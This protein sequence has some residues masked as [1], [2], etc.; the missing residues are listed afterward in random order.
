[1]SRDERIVDQRDPREMERWERAQMECRRAARANEWKARSS[2]QAEVTPNVRHGSVVSGG[3]ER[4]DTLF[5]YR[6]ALEDREHPVC[7]CGH[8]RHYH[9]A[10]GRWCLWGYGEIE[11]ECSCSTWRRA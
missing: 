1:M 9:G 3:E 4:T 8:A 6:Q 5:R 11:N 2:V 7:V 10:D